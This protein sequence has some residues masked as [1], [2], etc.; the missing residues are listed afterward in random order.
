MFAKVTVYHLL[1][2]KEISELKDLCQRSRSEQGNPVIKPQDRQEDGGKSFLRQKNG[3]YKAIERKSTP[4]YETKNYEIPLVSHAP[5]KV[6]NNSSRTNSGT[7][8]R[9]IGLRKTIS[10]LCNCEVCNIA[11]WRNVSIF[12]TL[13]LCSDLSLCTFEFKTNK[14]IDFKINQ[15]LFLV[16]KL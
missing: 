13:Y 1:K 15:K 7:S 9:W 3:Y 12:W 6:L 16:N 10:G 5:S 4:R 14:V 2:S 8:S 11:R